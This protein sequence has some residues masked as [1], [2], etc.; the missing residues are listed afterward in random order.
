M[1]GSF[2]LRLLLGFVLAA[3]CSTTATFALSGEESSKSLWIDAPKKSVNPWTTATTPSPKPG[4]LRQLKDWWYKGA[5]ND[6]YWRGLSPKDKVFYEIGQK[7][8]PA[9]QFEKFANLTPL[10]RG[11]ALVAESGWWGALRPTGTGW[12]LGAGTTLNTGPTPLVR[13]FTPRAAG[14]GAV[15]GTAWWLLSG[16][17]GDSP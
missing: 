2:P 12:R 14:A 6:A 16:D 15:G 10:E 1:I 13:W 7:T 4:R 5:E 3:T 8:L 11:R 9:G 17:E